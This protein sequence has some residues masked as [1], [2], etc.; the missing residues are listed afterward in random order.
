MK[1]QPRSISQFTPVTLRQSPLVKSWIRNPGTQEAKNL[2]V[3]QAPGRF[4][5]GFNWPLRLQIFPGFLPSSCPLS[6]APV[7]E[8]NRFLQYG[9]SENVSISPG[10]HQ[11]RLALPES[12]R[13]T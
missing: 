13:S 5:W 6:G 3:E 1:T 12:C 9:K 10:F 7:R 11:P 2:E 4:R 8:R